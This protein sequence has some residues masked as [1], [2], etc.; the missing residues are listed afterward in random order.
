[1]RAGQVRRGD[2]AVPLLEL[3]ELLGRALERAFDG[4]GRIEA[5]DREHLAALLRPDLED[6]VVAPLDVLGNVR[7]GAAVFAQPIDIQLP[8]TRV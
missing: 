3:G 2:D 4:R 6:Q 5:G 8:V 1:V 7:E